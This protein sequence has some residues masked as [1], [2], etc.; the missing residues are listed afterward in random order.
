MTAISIRYLYLMLVRMVVLL[1]TVSCSSDSNDPQLGPITY[2]GTG[3]FNLTG[4]TTFTFQG[5][6]D[7]VGIV[8]KFLPVFL[9]NSD[10]LTLKIG[11]NGDPEVKAGTYVTGVKPVQAF[12]S[13]TLFDELYE[14]TSGT[15]TLTSINENEIK[16]AVDTTISAFYVSSDD[17]FIKGTFELTAK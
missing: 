15:V 5:S 7:N 9:K 11:I 16:G 6:V 8:G 2:A 3:T 10:D 17:I 14:A 13:I 4:D 12:T 1:I